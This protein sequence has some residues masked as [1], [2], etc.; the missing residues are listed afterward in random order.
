VRLNQSFLKFTT[1]SIKS[2]LKAQ[3]TDP[4]GILQYFSYKGTPTV[5]SWWGWKQKWLKHLA[6]WV[7]L[8]LLASQ[9]DGNV[10]TATDSER[11]Q[12]WDLGSR[13]LQVT[14]PEARNWQIV[15]QRYNNLLITMSLI[16]GEL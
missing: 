3:P 10:I 2:L 8:T 13:T 12:T 15:L 14:Y 5:L 11:V 6:A 1:R 7:T 4:F 16:L 9:L